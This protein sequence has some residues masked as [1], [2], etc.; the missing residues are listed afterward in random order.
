MRARAVPQSRAPAARRWGWASNIHAGRSAGGSRPRAEPVLSPVLS[1]GRQSRQPAAEVG[2]AG[3]KGLA[4]G[5]LLP[6]DVE[7]LGDFQVASGLEGECWMWIKRMGYKGEREPGSRGRKTGLETVGRRKGEGERERGSK[8][9]ERHREKQREDMMEAERR[10]HK[11][12][13][14]AEAENRERERKK[15][16]N[17]GRKIESERE[18]HR[19]LGRKSPRDWPKRGGQSERQTDRYTR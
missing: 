10:T 6:D 19:G 16:G 13:G 12:D 7:F 14:K 8:R 18:T 11:R 2:R 17:T 9:R 4:W 5:S 3:R 15:G 1:P